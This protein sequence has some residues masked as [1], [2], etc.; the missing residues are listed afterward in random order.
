[1]TA[2]GPASFGSSTRFRPAR[3]GDVCVL[4]APRASP[5]AATVAAIVALQQ[6]LGGHAIEPLH[7]TCERFVEGGEVEALL[8][9]L[10]VHATAIAPLTVRGTSLFRWQPRAE[11]RAALKYLVDETPV[12]ARARAAV[13]DAA[14]AGR[15]SSAYGGE[16]QYTVTLLRDVAD[17]ALPDAPPCDLFVADGF[18]VS[19]IVGPDQYAT[20][21]FLDFAR[22]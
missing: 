17:G 4:L 9:R 20:L 13:G 7:I 1:M 14:L 2:Q 15:M 18:L 10:A 8:A 3:A 12:L 5:P 19:R 22:R 16:T 6:Q 11:E 21:A